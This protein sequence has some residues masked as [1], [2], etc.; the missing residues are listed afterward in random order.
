MKP[1]HRTEAGSVLLGVL[2][3]AV[4]M[5]SVCLGYAR[6]VVLASSVP[7]ASLAAQAAEG[8]AD[9]GLAW[10]RQ[11]LLSARSSGSALP[12]SDEAEVSISLTPAGGDLQS[13]AIGSSALGESQ[14][15]AGTVET[16]ATGDGSLPRFTAA[17]RAAITTHGSV[18]V[19]SGTQSYANTTLT[20]LLL[21]RSGTSLTLNNCIVAGSIVSAA[22][23][24]GA[25]WSGAD[26]VSITLLGTVVLESDAALP[27]CSLVAPDAR[28]DGTGAAVQ[29]RGALVCDSLRLGSW[30]SVHGPVAAASTL[31]VPAGIDQPGAGREP[32]AFPAALET[33]ALDIARVS[34]PRATASPADQDAIESFTFPAA[35][36]AVAPAR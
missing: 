17:A 6:H 35:R 30:G 5:A 18:T 31:S 22:A 15:L 10:A 29:I 20:G 34:F 3:L 25:T 26:P 36:R 27:D 24:S 11:A 13:L 28:V 23:A 7:E 33:G 21:L 9:S 32:R 12:I 4:L 19:I 2:L 16:Y 14:A 8:A 1:V